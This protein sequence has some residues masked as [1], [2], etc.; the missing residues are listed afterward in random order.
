MTP[1]NLLCNVIA[2][3]GALYRYWRQGQTG[4]Q[5]AL[6]LITGTM[7]GVIAGSVTRAKL[8]PGPRV[9]DL[10][11][12]AVLIPLGWPANQAPRSLACSRPR[13]LAGRRSRIRTSSS[14]RPIQD[15]ARPQ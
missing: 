13:P 8:I 3:P 6:V 9:F 4:G 12:G 15:R 11:T 1:T 5:L 7:P 14:S 10:V 2:T